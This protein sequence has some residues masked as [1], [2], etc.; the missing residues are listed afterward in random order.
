MASAR[1]MPSRWRRGVPIPSFFHVDI[2]EGVLWLVL[3]PRIVHQ[4][5]DTQ[6]EPL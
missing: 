5:P 4:H 6:P 1:W 3:R 2:V